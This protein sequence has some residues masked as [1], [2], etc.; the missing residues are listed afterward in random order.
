MSAV[1]AVAI[2]GHAASGVTDGVAVGVVVGVGVWVWADMV[3]TV[4]AATS[5]RVIGTLL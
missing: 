2:S 3:M 4:N 1:S 5:T